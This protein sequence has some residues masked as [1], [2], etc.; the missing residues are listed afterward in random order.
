MC[1]RWRNNHTVLS[2]YD[3]RLCSSH[4]VTIVRSAYVELLLIDY[5]PDIGSQEA[6][7]S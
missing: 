6:E 4:C 5:M 7:H 3:S 2:N 1:R